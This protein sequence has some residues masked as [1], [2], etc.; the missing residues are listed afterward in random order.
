M[1]VQSTSEL[2]RSAYRYLDDTGI[3]TSTVLIGAAISIHTTIF[4][5]YQAVT[6]TQ[7]VTSRSFLCLPNAPSGSLSTTFLTTSTLTCSRHSY[8]STTDRPTIS[9]GYIIPLRCQSSVSISIFLLPSNLSS[10]SASVTSSPQP[11]FRLSAPSPARFFSSAELV[12]SRSA[13]SE[14]R[15]PQ[16][17]LDRAH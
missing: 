7:S 13:A 14:R 2:H 11:F 4:H 16:L 15:S 17:H 1:R 12:A 10:P 3:V 5:A 9:H 6:F 8:Y